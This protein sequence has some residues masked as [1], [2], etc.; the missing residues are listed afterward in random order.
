MPTL[1]AKQIDQ[2][3]GIIGA[4]SHGRNARV[5]LLAVLTGLAPNPRDAS[6]LSEYEGKRILAR[7][8]LELMDASFLSGRSDS[9]SSDDLPRPKREPV[10]YAGRGRSLRRVAEPEPDAGSSSGG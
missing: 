2:A 4:T 3:W 10:S 1:E 8:L 9:S 7:E 6:A 5:K